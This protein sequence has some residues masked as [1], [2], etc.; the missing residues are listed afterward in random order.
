MKNSLKILAVF[1]GI[2]AG[3]MLGVVLWNPYSRNIWEYFLAFI[4]FV[5]AIITVI[6]L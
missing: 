1:F 4:A 6:P 5:G 3:F 2:F